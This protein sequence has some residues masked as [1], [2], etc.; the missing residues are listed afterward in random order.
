MSSRWSNRPIPG[1]PLAKV[2]NRRCKLTL[3]LHDTSLAAGSKRPKGCVGLL[4]LGEVYF[5]NSTPQTN[6]DRVSAVVSAEF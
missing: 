5:D 4:L 3:P 6:R 2:E 1:Q